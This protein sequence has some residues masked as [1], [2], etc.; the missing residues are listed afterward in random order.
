MA[1]VF[2][3]AVINPASSYPLYKIEPRSFGKEYNLLLDNYSA[4]FGDPSSDASLITTNRNSIGLCFTITGTTNANNST[5]FYVK[6]VA[7]STEKVFFIS[8]WLNRDV[9]SLSIEDYQKGFLGFDEG[10]IM[11]EMEEN[12]VRG[13]AIAYNPE[14]EKYKKA[15]TGDFVIGY[16]F[17][18]FDGKYNNYTPTINNTKIARVKCNLK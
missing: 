10:M 13:D 12:V 3:S 4:A 1:N 9:S 15:D 11:L 14:T 5:S 17:D 18:F 16:V 7:T 2:Q 8:A 6:K